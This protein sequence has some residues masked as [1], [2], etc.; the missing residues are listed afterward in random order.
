MVFDNSREYLFTLETVFDFRQ[1]CANVTHPRPLSRGEIWML[2]FFLVMRG[3]WRGGF[4]SREGIKGCVMVRCAARAEGLRKAVGRSVMVRS[5]GWAE[6]I[7]A[8]VWG[9]GISCV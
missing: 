6:M 3:L 2:F 8:A 4:P 7:F 9:C 1:L 5:A